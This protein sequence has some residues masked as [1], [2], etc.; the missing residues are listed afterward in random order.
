MLALVSDH[1]IQHGSGGQEQS[2]NAFSR[3]SDLRRDRL[4]LCLPSL[5]RVEIVLPRAYSRIR[6]LANA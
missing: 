4:L 5:R 3:W 2:V 1:G 6:P